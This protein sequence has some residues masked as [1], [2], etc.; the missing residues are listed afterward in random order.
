MKE[1]PFSRV[2]DRAVE[3]FPRWSGMNPSL[4]HVWLAECDPDLDIIPTMEV[5]A[6]KK[7]DLNSIA[8]LTPIIKS[9]RDTRLRAEQSFKD[10][11]RPVDND[12]RAAAIEFNMKHGIRAPE[13]ERWLAEY[14]KKNPSVISE[15]VQSSV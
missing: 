7:P 2:Y 13:D 8:Y 4:I 9:A 11:A 14:L 12:R 15:G 6:K 5:I 10:M 1:T 3:L